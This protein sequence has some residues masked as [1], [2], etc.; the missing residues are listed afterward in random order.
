ML[1][2]ELLGALVEDLKEH[3]SDQNY[4]DYVRRDFRTVVVG[5]NGDDVITLEAMETRNKVQAK[6]SRRWVLEKVIDDTEQRV[7]LDITAGFTTSA[8]FDENFVYIM[9][10]PSRY[11]T[12][13]TRSMIRKLFAIAR[14]K[15]LLAGLA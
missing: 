10:N 8:R 7:W 12:C 9:I 3:D 2:F 1:A 14:A 6:I 4:W 13:H 11:S 5:K 15:Y